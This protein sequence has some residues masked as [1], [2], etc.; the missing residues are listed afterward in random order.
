MTKD[1][2][3]MHYTM[4]ETK[5]EHSRMVS[6]CVNNTELQH[7]EAQNSWVENISLYNHKLNAYH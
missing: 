5:A 2:L 6:C 7:N 4:F 1:A 3:S